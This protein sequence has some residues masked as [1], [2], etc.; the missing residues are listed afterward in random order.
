VDPYIHG[1][2][3]Y[4][5]AELVRT[6]LH[7]RTKH[8]LIMPL[9]TPGKAARVFRSGANLAASRAVGHRTWEDFL[10]ARLSLPSVRAS[11][12]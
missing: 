10:T 11:R 7:A 6:S 2:R 4:E 12:A 8:R 5:M 1:P 3:L 9:W